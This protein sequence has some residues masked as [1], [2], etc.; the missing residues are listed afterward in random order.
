MKTMPVGSS[1]ARLGNAVKVG[2]LV[3]LAIGAAWFLYAQVEERAGARRS[4]QVYAIFED[5]QGLVEKSRVEIAGISVGYIERIS[6]VRAETG[7]PRARID[8]D[9]KEE[10]KLYSGTGPNHEGGATIQKRM[11][12]L[13][14]EFA[15]VITPGT[16]IP[17]TE[18]PDGGRIPH[19]L[20]EGSL[21]SVINQMGDVLGDVGVIARELKRVAEQLA[22]TFGTEEGGDQM[23]QAL[24]DLAETAAGVNRI[25][26]ENSM[27]I[28]RTL[29]N[30]DQITA[31]GAPEI[32]HILENTRLVTE[33]VRTLVESQSG[34]VG[35][36]IGDL[37][38]TV[39]SL[40]RAA[41]TLERTLTHAENIAR[42]VEEGRGTVGRLLGDEGL[43]D[44]VEGVAEG[45]NDF[46]GGINRLQTIVGLRSEYNLL[47]NTFKSYVELR[48]QPREDKYYVLQVIDDPRGDT[49]FSSTVYTNRGGPADEPAS[50]RQDRVTT[51]D[52][53]RFSFQFARR[54]GP[55]TG[56]FG[57][58]ESTGGIGADLNL[59]G[60]QLELRNDLFA[61]G[62]NVYPRYRANLAFEI[63]K[64][65]WVLGGV[66]DVLNEGRRDYHLGAQLR[67]NDQD[68]K[69]I[70]PFTPTP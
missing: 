16:P 53:F 42:S 70:L 17:G 31:E 13:L 51:T 68:L 1:S 63:V 30:V 20:G 24:T 59:M 11:T 2:I 32:R 47:A 45:I 56:R 18:I 66:D 60:D 7:E 44:E 40:N 5:A 29:R 4:Y 37:R 14:G 39:M 38:E 46:V 55:F 69:A 62:E 41:G 15:L 33:Q 49:E 22:R 65:I 3:V 43:I 61:F 8:L 52:A 48:L 58:M 12:S 26:A 27:L 57:I 19:V 23:R 35:G 9:I 50:W 10:V 25:V 67:F 54:V 64:R 34:N 21:F 28:N 36:A 6:L